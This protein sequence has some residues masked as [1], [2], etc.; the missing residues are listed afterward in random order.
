MSV[1][2]KKRSAPRIQRDIAYEQVRI[3]VL[4][5][6]VGGTAVVPMQ[7]FAPEVALFVEEHTQIVGAEVAQVEVFELECGGHGVCS[8]LNLNRGCA[9]EMSRFDPP[10]PNGVSVGHCGHSEK[11]FVVF[12]RWRNPD[13]NPVP[14]GDS[15]RYRAWN[16]PSLMSS[17][18]YHGSP[19]GPKN[20]I[21]LKWIKWLGVSAIHTSD[22]QAIRS[23]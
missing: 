23:M 22:S 7:A 6:Q 12:C 14:E 21:P 8:R 15:T 16:F 17:M 4:Q 10:A 13:A 18:K 9:A 2:E 20:L 1:M 11:P 3:D 19:Y 5:Q